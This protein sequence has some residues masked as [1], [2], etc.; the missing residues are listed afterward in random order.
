VSGGG[1]TP[2]FGPGERVL[3]AIGEAVG[4]K[5]VVLGRISTAA[6]AEASA[7]EGSARPE[8]RAGVTLVEDQRVVLRAKDHLVLECG[9][10]TIEIRSD[11]RIVVHG[12]RI[13]SRARGTHRIKGGTVAIN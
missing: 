7:G 2:R 11:G 3:V 6:P 10:A 8:G 9:G 4:P 1:P 13:L 12:D 5:G